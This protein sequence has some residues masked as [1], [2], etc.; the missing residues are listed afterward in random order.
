MYLLRFII[1]EVQVLFDLVFS[2][3]FALSDALNN[4]V[5]HKDTQI[6]VLDI[7][8][9]FMVIILDKYSF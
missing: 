2:L 7:C 3:L 4:L 6:N 9:L 1:I 8:K 5:F